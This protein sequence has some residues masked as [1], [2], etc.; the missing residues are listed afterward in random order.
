[1]PES[2]EAGAAHMAAWGTWYGS[3]GAGV[4]DPGAPFGA[5]HAVAANGS[6]SEGGTSALSG[7]SVIAAENFAEALEAAKRCPIFEIGG[8]VDVL[9]DPSRCDP[10]GR[11]DRPRQ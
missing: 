2:Q 8:A 10:C 1:M 3:L 6:T 11:H 7:Y 9:R 5:S 4:I